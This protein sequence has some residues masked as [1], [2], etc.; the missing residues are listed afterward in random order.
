MQEQQRIEQPIRRRKNRLKARFFSIFLSLFILAMIGYFFWQ[1]THPQIPNLHG[2]SSTE[3]LDFGKDH[4]MDIQ[5]EFIYSRDVAPTL[6][7]SQSI[8]PR[9]AISEGMDLTVEISKGV[10]VR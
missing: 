9:T 1:T 2:W 4:E 3:V 8:P 7:I 10:E 6:V 5:F